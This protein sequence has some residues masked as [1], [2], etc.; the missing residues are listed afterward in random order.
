MN[1]MLY[2]IKMRLLVPIHAVG[3]RF[4]G[5]ERMLQRAVKLA[6]WTVTLQFSTHYV[7]R[8][9]D[10]AELARRAVVQPNALQADEPALLPGDAQA[11]AA[12][13]PNTATP[14]VSPPRKDLREAFLVQHGT[15]LIHFPPVAAPDV[16]VIIPV[17]KGLADLQTCLR[18]L[19][20]YREQEPSFDVILIDDCPA[21]PVLWA[22]P[23]SG[24]LSKLA[25]GENL[26]SL[27][28]CN[29]AA[30][31]AQGRI[32]CFLDSDTIVSR[33]WLQSRAI[34]YDP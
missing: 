18:S 22:V 21:E 31:S 3:T 26:G 15:A 17:Y 23:D 11:D 13:S 12:P 2:T 30:A 27:L 9:R 32:L 16:T 20:V 33:N 8:R 6:F 34:A 25:N 1:A 7:A 10:R 5:L 14:S 24:G 4:P 29:R 28:A 19:A